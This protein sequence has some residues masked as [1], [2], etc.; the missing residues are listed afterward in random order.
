MTDFVSIII[1]YGSS[2]YD[3]LSLPGA[4]SKSRNDHL[5]GSIF[6]VL[7]YDWFFNIFVLVVCVFF[8]N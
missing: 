1:I 5:F 6:Q 2:I 7:T 3:N 4:H 8:K